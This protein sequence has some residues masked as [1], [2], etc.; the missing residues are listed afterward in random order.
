MWRWTQENPNLW[1]ACAFL[2]GS[3]VFALAIVHDW[4]T[5]YRCFLDGF[6][7]LVFLAIGLKQLWRWR[8]QQLRM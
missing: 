5:S 6:A 2:V 8:Q 7:A 3:A 4:Q 1:S